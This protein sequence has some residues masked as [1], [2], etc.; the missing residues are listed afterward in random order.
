MKMECLK[1]MLP[2]L[3][4]KTVLV[5]VCDDKAVNGVVEQQ[6]H[7]VEHEI[8][9]SLGKDSHARPSWHFF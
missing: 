8:V 2:Q 4:P 7:G 6:I 1:A 9:S 3:P 5:T